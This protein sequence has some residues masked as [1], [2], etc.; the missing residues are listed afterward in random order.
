MGPEPANQQFQSIIAWLTQPMDGQFIYGLWATGDS[1]KP[2]HKG[3][4]YTA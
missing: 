3:F 2:K 1:V 4:H